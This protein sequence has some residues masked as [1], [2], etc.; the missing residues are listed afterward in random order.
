GDVKLFAAAGAWLGP[1]LAWRAAVAAALLGGAFAVAT[2]AWSRRPRRRQLRS[3]TLAPDL[4][5]RGVPYAVP[6]AIALALAAA[7]PRAFPFLP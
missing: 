3:R 7:L 5:D 1:A 4:P 6:M 2:L